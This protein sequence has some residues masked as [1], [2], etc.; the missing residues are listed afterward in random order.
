MVCVVYVSTSSA[1]GEDYVSM[2]KNGKG[3]RQFRRCKKRD[4]VM[5]DIIDNI[6]DV[7]ETE[8]FNISIEL[9]NDAHKYAELVD[10]TGAVFILARRM[11]RCL[12]NTPL[13][14][15]T[16]TYTHTHTSNCQHG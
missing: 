8:Y 12:N 2:G 5:I 9:E 14:H 16:H 15:S 13:M 7:E 4:C 6:P 11:Y 1:A 10:T 3:Q